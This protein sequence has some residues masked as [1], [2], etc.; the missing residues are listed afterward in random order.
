M[1]SENVGCGMGDNSPLWWLGAGGQI[2]ENTPLCGIGTKYHIGRRGVHALL[3]ACPLARG[4]ACLSCLALAL[5]A[6][7]WPETWSVLPGMAVSPPPPSSL[8]LS[9]PLSHVCHGLPYIL[10]M[11]AVFLSGH[12]CP[13][14]LCRSTLHICSPCAGAIRLPVCLHC[15][16]VNGYCVPCQ[17]SRAVIVSRSIMLYG[18]T[19]VIMKLVG[20]FPCPCVCPIAGHTLQV[21]HFVK[22]CKTFAGLVCIAFCGLLWG[23]IGVLQVGALLRPGYPGAADKAVFV[24]LWG[25]VCLY[26]HFAGLHGLSCIFANY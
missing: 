14:R 16:L 7:V 3:S 12:V 18:G 26:I 4:L 2:V 10:P 8:P 13:C 23:C 5:C 15:E 25:I 11:F 19:S 17:P 24:R 20:L 9:L 6:A 21:F 22:I 1:R